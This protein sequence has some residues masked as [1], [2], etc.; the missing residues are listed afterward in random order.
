VS[1]QGNRVQ[2]YGAVTSRQF[3]RTNPEYTERNRKRS[4]AR[5][6]ALE[7]LAR[8]HV[9]EFA[10]LYAAELAHL[11]ID[12]STV[13]MTRACPCGGVITRKVPA[14]RW[15]ERC[16]DCRKADTREEQE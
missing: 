9:A 10:A 15:P 7:A 4:Q 6:E 5:G 8:K 13:A 12:G 2:S 1:G 14:G 11:G 16:D 3:R